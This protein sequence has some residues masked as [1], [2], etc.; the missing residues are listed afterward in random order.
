MN[1]GIIC[2]VNLSIGQYVY[3]YTNILDKNNVKYDVIFWNRTG[4]EEKETIKGR[5]ISYEVRMDSELPF[6]KKVTKF[7][8]YVHFLKDKISLKQYDRLIILT[9]QS[10]IPLASI[11]LRYYKK[12]YIYD[13]R[14][15]T[16]EKQISVYKQLVTKLI[17][18]SYCTMMSSP[19][20]IDELGLRRIKNIQIA[21]NSRTVAKSNFKAKK[22]NTV[23]PIR[24]SFWG[25]V[26]PLG[27]NKKFCDLL[28]N[29]NRFQ[30]FY[31]GLGH[32]KELKSYC[33]EKK[34]KNIF[35][36][37]EYE[38]ADIPLFVARTDIL[39]CAYENDYVQK[40][41]MPVKAYD[42]IRYRLPV[43][44]SAGSEVANFF[45]GTAGALSVNLQK[46]NIADDIFNWYRNLD[47]IKVERDYERL[48]DI[49]Y[50]DDLRFERTL[51]RF[52]EG[53]PFKK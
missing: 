30:L 10:A 16:K 6:I 49:I 20:F 4:S 27:L 5:C 32:I 22:I 47:P 28:G 1:I 12:K 15:V 45:D 26:R 21:H 29:D 24:I 44:I 2:F 25:L 23:G 53:K 7:I 38:L 52:V 18:Y 51:M 19:G 43:L 13:Y 48:E 35:F 11:L 9:T 37:G 39:H 33:I 46:N 8:G 41:A 36:S 50:K 31:S 34:Y 3:K 40:P 14:D 42:A 17:H